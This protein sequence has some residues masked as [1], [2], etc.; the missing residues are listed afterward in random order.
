MTKVLNDFIITFNNQVLLVLMKAPGCPESYRQEIEGCMTE[1]VAIE[2]CCGGRWYNMAGPDQP[3][4][5]VVHSSAVFSTL[6]VMPYPFKSDIGVSDPCMRLHGPTNS[7]DEMRSLPFV[8]RYMEDN[9]GGFCWKG[10]IDRSLSVRTSQALAE[11]F[12]TFQCL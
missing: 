1:K 7:N 8:K 6:Y 9:E 4:G 2:R 11:T 12:S 10:F 5:I 3:F